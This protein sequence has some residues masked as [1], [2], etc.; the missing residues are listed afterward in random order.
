MSHLPPSPSKRI[1]ARVTSNFFQKFADIF[2]S[3]GAPPVATTLAANLPSTTTVATLPPQ[4]SRRFQQHRWQTMGPILDCLHL[5]VNLKKQIYQYVNSTTQRCPHKIFKTF[6]I[7]NLL[8]LQ[9]SPQ[10]FEKFETPL[11]G[12]SG[13]WEKLIHEKYLKSKISWN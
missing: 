1:N 5:E 4:I 7:E 8:H 12:Y 2:A 9:I 11:T 10:I 3:Q 13:A 6:L